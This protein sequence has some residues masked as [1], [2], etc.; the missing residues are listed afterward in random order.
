MKSQKRPEQDVASRLHVG[1]VCADGAFSQGLESA[2]SQSFGANG[3][4]GGGPIISQRQDADVLVY[5]F[6]ESDVAVPDFVARHSESIRRDTAPTK[7]FLELV[8]ADTLGPAAQA[9][10]TQNKLIAQLAHDHGG[11]LVPLMSKFM[12]WDPGRLLT[13][14]GALNRRGYQAIAR[15]V[16]KFIDRFDVRRSLSSDEPAEFEGRQKPEMPASEILSSLIW[17]SRQFPRSIRFAPDAQNIADFLDDRV[18]FASYPGWGRVRIS[19]PVDWSMPGPNRSWQSYFLGLEFLGPSLGL[20]LA[21]A[22]GIRMRDEPTLRKM[23]KRNDVTPALLLERTGAVIADFIGANPPEQP[24]AQRAWHEGT[25]CRRLRILLS[26]LICCQAAQK[27]GEHV[28]EASVS[29][30]FASIQSSVEMLR[31]ERIYIKSGNHGVRQDMLLILTG[32]LFGGMEFGRELAREGLNR[33]TRHQLNTMLSADGVWLENSFEYHR[34]IMGVLSDLA[35]DMQTMSQPGS[36][37]L[38]D[39]VKRMLTFAEAVVTC[40]GYAPLI[41]DTTPREALRGIIAARALLDAPNVDRDDDTSGAFERTQDTYLFPNSGYFASHSGRAMDP[42][43]SSVI[44]Y[45]NL[46][47]PKH[48]HADDLSV[49][50]SHGATDL[51][52]DGGTYN[53]ETSD[54]VRNAARFDP[55]T[56]NTYRMNGKGYSVRAA[57]HKSLAGTTAMWSGDGWAGAHGYNKAYPDGRIDRFVIHLKHHSA[58]IVVDKLATGSF[59]KAADFEQFWHIAPDFKL[60]G[61]ATEG[62]LA[63]QSA[64]NGTL[65]VAFDDANPAYAVEH[66]GPDNP[67]AWLMTRD[68]E[69]VPTPYIRRA[70]RMRKGYMA[71]LFQ[72][73][74]EPHD[75]RIGFSSRAQTQI[76]V[77]GF[78]FSAR[79]SVDGGRI[80]RAHLTG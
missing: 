38:I 56:H 31:S 49:I 61:S 4:V 67:L 20:W 66:G 16:A 53:K 21:L 8:S 73:A 5:A 70:S 42:N 9:I 63:F 39:A 69:T 7:V 44:F 80:A 64:A 3:G 55:A 59:W 68:D 77:V 71:S 51:L 41:G 40:D 52:I 58:L 18:S 76:D 37:Q 74:T 48:K 22:H 75:A 45:A 15:T 79:F 36:E 57:S 29:A 46:S 24:M 62:R 17:N 50:F 28:D 43:G 13:D 27:R 25:V 33:L 30:A 60:L 47:E 32:M 10:A 11:Y 14:S 34:L 72:W 78:G 6:A 19:H 26:Y 12:R 2:L 23:V 65:L 54:D 35:A 1:I